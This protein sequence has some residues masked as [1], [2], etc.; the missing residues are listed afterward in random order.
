MTC[1]NI[2]RGSPPKRPPSSTPRITAAPS[3]TSPP[4]QPDPDRRGA[5][6]TSPTTHRSTC[7]RA[8][9]SRMPR[10]AVRPRRNRPLR[11]RLPALRTRSRAPSTW[12]P[13][14]ISA[15][16]SCRAFRPASRSRQDGRPA[17]SDLIILAGRPGMGKTSLATNIAFNI[18]KA[19]RWRGAA[20]RPTKTSQWRHCRL[21]LARNERRAARHPYHRRA[22]RRSPPPRSAAAITETSSTSSSSR[23]S[24]EMQALPL[25]IDDTGGLSIASSPPAPAP[26]APARPRP[27]GRRLS[28]AALRLVQEGREPRAGAD[29]DHHRPQGAG[30][31]AEGAGHRA[32]A[33]L[34]S[35]GKPRRQ[36]PAALRPARIRLDRAG[37]R[38]GL[39][40]YREEYYLKNKEPKP[41]TPSTR[42]GRPR[43]RRSMAAPR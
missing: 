35:G 21:L 43:W 12:R 2:S 7:R 1:R 34:A 39:F 32:V 11:R 40:V 5:W 41:G 9:R 26:E 29:R 25:Y 18:A 8:S 10:R 17:A 22:G 24:R 19:Y 30:Q 38:R 31:G 16:A 3:T 28:P 23:P 36:A 37:R 6:S 27:P 13:P 15:T 4:P 42:N 14:P 20:G 33:A